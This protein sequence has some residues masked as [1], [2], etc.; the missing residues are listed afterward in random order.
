[1][2]DRIRV[3]RWEGHH[4]NAQSRKCAGP[5]SWVRVP[6]S[7]KT[8]YA[9]LVA[10]HGLF[11]LGVWLA[12]LQQAADHPR[13]ERGFTYA[14]PAT[15]ALVARSDDETAKIGTVLA[16]LRDDCGWIAIEPATSAGST[17]ALPLSS[18][19]SGSVVARIP[20]SL[21][22]SSES[23]EEKDSP[24]KEDEPWFADAVN[25]TPLVARCRAAYEAKYHTPHWHRADASLE[26]REQDEHALRLLSEE[27]GGDDVVVERFSVLVG[28]RTSKDQRWLWALTRDMAEQAPEAEAGEDWGSAYAEVDP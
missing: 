3:V 4:E 16:T 22:P 19:G 28:A 14:D 6:T 12:I 9:I 7:Q 2:P 10:R 15:I 23:E 1:M 24:K 5:L 11:G 20:P 17:T 26:Q 8:G 25:G 27:L 21:P 13:D 18:Q